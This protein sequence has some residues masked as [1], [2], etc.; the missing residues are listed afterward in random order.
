MSISTIKRT[1][2]ENKEV[3]FIKKSR[4]KSKENLVYREFFD[5]R[6]QQMFF[7]KTESFPDGSFLFQK[8]ILIS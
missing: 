6:K 7:D 2:S 5:K 3:F 4:K 1:H 8:I